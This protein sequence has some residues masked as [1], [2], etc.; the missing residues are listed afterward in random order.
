[1]TNTAIVY[2]SGYGHTAKQAEA[3]TR[4]NDWLFDAMTAR[5]D[6]ELMRW[7]QAPDSAWNHPTNDH[8][9]PLFTVLGTTAGSKSVERIHESID[10]AVLAMDA[11]KL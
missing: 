1:M 5:D 2:F 8:F 7:E 3:V 9:L 10:Y 11:Y 4:F 6:E